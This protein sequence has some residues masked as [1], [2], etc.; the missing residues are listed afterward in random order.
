M[1]E[2]LAIQHLTC[3][4]H[5]RWILATP[6]TGVLLMSQEQQQ[7]GES[8]QSLQNT[9]HLYSQISMKKARSRGEILPRESRKP[10]LNALQINSYGVALLNSL[11][12]L[13]GVITTS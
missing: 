6:F 13:H 10:R 12:H 4:R 1:R 2:L 7:C 5:L 8:R 3:R 11:P 9:N